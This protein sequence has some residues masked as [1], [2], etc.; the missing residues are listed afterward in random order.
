MDV[1]ACAGSGT[2]GKLIESEWEGPNGDVLKYRLVRCLYCQRRFAVGDSVQPTPFYGP[3]G[4]VTL[5]RQKRVWYIPPHVNSPF[6]TAIRR[7]LEVAYGT[8]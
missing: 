7:W 5:I 1:R 6:F 2:N 4:Q 3:D 8:S